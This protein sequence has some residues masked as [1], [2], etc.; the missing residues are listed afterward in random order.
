[1]PHCREFCDAEPTAQ[2]AF[3]GAVNFTNENSVGFQKICRDSVGR[4]VPDRLDF[5]AQST[6]VGVEEDEE[7]LFSG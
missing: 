1:V 6:L 7:E 2:V 3:F 5:V 4:P